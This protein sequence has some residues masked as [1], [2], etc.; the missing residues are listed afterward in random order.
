MEVKVAFSY[1]KK[2]KIGAWFLKAFMR[3]PYSHVLVYWESV[4][5]ERTLVYHAA[6]GQVHFIEKHNFLKQND[7]VKEFAITVSEEQRI[8]L[9]QRCVDLAGQP[10]AYAELV[11]MG[12]HEL[13]GEGYIPKDCPGYVCST[14]L[15]ELLEDILGKKLNKPKHLVKPNDIEDLLT[16]I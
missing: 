14:L 9:M 1:P 16:S 3:R 12:I 11:T 15:A 7:I 6:H 13:L 4:S 5:L 10:Y 2:F 8:A